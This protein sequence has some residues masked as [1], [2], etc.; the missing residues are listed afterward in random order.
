MIIL[1]RKKIDEHTFK[2]YDEKL[3]VTV[4]V[5]LSIYPD[6][7]ED[8]QDLIE[9]SDKAMYLAKSSGKNIVCEYAE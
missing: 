1:K 4:S 6:D 9:K 5:G 3:K 7:S 8:A 2:A